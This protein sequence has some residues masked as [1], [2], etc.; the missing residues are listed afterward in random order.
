[1]SDNKLGKELIKAMG[2]AYGDLSPLENATDEA[3]EQAIAHQQT[4][5]DKSAEIVRAAEKELDEAQTTD[6]ALWA[7]LARLEHEKEIRLRLDKRAQ[8]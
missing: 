5:A 8:N 7:T 2:A 4:R 3:L 6:D 1:M